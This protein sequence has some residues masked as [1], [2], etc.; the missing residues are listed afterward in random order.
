MRLG[1][2]VGLLALALT[3][4]IVTG[5]IDLS[6]GALLG[7]CAVVFGALWRDAGMVAVDGR[8]R[9]ARDLARSAAR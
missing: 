2:E 6:C 7:L 1:V 5:G 8:A 3:P 4:I 9:R